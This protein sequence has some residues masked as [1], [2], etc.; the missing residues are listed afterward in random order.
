MP[1][2]AGSSGGHCAALLVLVA[3]YFPSS[4]HGGDNT[5]F[6]LDD[7]F[8]NVTRFCSISSSLNHVLSAPWRLLRQ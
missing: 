3:G 2:T 1:C 7:I 8:V 4:R 5:L 6:R